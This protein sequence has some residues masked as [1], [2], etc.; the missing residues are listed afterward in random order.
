MIAPPRS[1]N[2]A[3][4]PAYARPRRSRYPG[5]CRGGVGMRTGSPPSSGKLH[6]SAPRPA[7]NSFP[8]ANSVRP[9]NGISRA[10]S[11]WASGV[12]RTAFPAIPTARTEPAG[13]IARC[14]IPAGAQDRALYPILHPVRPQFVGPV[15]VIDGAP[16]GRPHSLPNRG[17]GRR[18]RPPAARLRHLAHAPGTAPTGP[19]RR[20]LPPAGCS[21]PETTPP[22]RCAPCGRPPRVRHRS[23]SPA[24]PGRG[25]PRRNSPCPAGRGTPAT[26]PSRDHAGALLRP[27]KRVRIGSPPTEISCTPVRTP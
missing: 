5:V 13:L 3:R 23:R 10:T 24:P 15:Q 2:R 12:R 26:L 25:R 20:F 22:A 18:A 6:N 21:R 1:R 11:P 9:E 19:F 14:R 8:Q 7:Y 16:I 17:T 4:T 27:A